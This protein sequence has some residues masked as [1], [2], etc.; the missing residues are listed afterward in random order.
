MRSQEFEDVSLNSDSGAAR[1]LDL[2]RQ[3]PGLA[4]PLYAQGAGH[5]ESVFPGWILK[6]PLVPQRV[7]AV[8]GE[9][10]AVQA[11]KVFRLY[12][13]ATHKFVFYL[14]RDATVIEGIAE[15]MAERGGFEPP[16]EL[17]TL[18]RFSKPLLSTTQPPLR[19]VCGRYSLDS[20]TS[21]AGSEECVLERC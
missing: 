20:S 8:I 15:N 1:L 9:R 21:L 4:V 3:L 7:S 16:V 6:R 12:R 11:C 5:N 18:R 17:L 10:P 2:L 14:I 13:F 19:D